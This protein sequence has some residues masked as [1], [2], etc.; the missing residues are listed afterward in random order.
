MSSWSNPGESIQDAI[1]RAAPGSVIRVQPGEYYESITIDANRITL[2]GGDGTPATRP[3]LDGHGVHSDA[4][5]VSGRDF[6]MSNFEVRHYVGNGVVAQETTNFTLKDSKLEDTGLYGVYPVRSSFVKIQRVEVIGARDAG[7]YVGQSKGIVVED[8]VAHGNVTG[9]EIENSVDARVE[10]NHV[11]DNAGGILV[12]ALPGNPSKEAKRTRVA[13]N[14]I[15]ANNHENFADPGLD[16]LQGALG[17][18]RLHP[19]RGRHGGDGERDPRQQLLWG[20]RPRTRNP[21]PG[22]ADRST[23]APSPTARAFTRTR[24]PGMEVRPTRRSSPPASRA[25]TCCGTSPDPRTSGTSLGATTAV[26]VLDER[27]PAFMRR[28]MF[29]FLTRAKSR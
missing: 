18:R 23:W 9:I 10:R 11:Y 1:D 13:R 16:R 22:R 25:P 4:V 15:I 5:I 8:C 20:R 3:A 12:F 24:S 21:V 28:V 26:P 7:I 6:T 14:K 2:I 29:Q 19:G 17:R 27:W